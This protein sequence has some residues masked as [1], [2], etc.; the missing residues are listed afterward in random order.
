MP[1]I[2]NL[3]SI[4]VEACHPHPL[5]HLDSVDST[6][7]YARTLLSGSQRPEHLTTVIA[8]HQ[9][10][11]RGRLG[12]TWIT[13]PFSALTATT[14]LQ[15]PSPL[16]HDAPA[17]CLHATSLAIR[18]TL[19]PLLNP[20]GHSVTTKWPNDVLIDGER[21][22]CGILAEDLG[23]HSG[24]HYLA[25]GYGV[26]IAM[27]ADKRP[28]PHATALDLEGDELA[29]SDP[30]ARRR[31]LLGDIL[32]GLH[33]RLKTLQEE[34]WDATASG[35]FEEAQRHCVTLGHPVALPQPHQPSLNTQKV[36]VTYGR[37]LALDHS[38]ALIVEREDGT[39]ILITT[40]D[41]LLPHEYQP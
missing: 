14:L 35:L 22:I 34:Q 13:A 24:T 5:I 3:E 31:L 2:S 10:A 37:A 18:D 36:P 12:R 26:N 4:D 40:G 19:A 41:V 21:K 15:L 39:H 30:L 29:I 11:G 33:A 28:T 16:P 23:T 20:H 8:D 25:V 17:W 38:G 6:N 32:T 27:D 1:Y 9:R 7:S